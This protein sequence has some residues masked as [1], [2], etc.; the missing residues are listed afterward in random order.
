[1]NLYVFECA[2]EVYEN[3]I[4]LVIANND[5]EAFEID[6]PSHTYP[7]RIICQYKLDDLMNYIPNLVHTINQG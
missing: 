2:G 6:Q 4:N 1:M 5:Q 3:Q 7:R